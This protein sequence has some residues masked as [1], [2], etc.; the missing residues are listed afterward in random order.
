MSKANSN[1]KGKS[2]SASNTNIAEL[3]LLHP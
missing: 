1:Q 3:L 2:E